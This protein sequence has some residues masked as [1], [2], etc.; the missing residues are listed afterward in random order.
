MQIDIAF[1]D[2]EIILNW[3]YICSF[4]RYIACVKA[5]YLDFVILS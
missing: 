3:I 2:I 5:V 1:V 4:Y